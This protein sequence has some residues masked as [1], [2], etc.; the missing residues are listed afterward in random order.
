MENEKYTLYGV[1]IYEKKQDEEDEGNT[2]KKW[3]GIKRRLSQKDIENDFFDSTKEDEED[4]NIVTG[5]KYLNDISNIAFDT[6]GQVFDI[7]FA[8]NEEEGDEEGDGEDEEY[9]YDTVLESFLVETWNTSVK[10]KMGKI[11]K[12]KNNKRVV[13]LIHF[14]NKEDIKDFDSEEK[15]KLENSLAELGLAEDNY[16]RSPKNIAYT[17]SLW[18]F[19]NQIER[20]K[21]MENST[22]HWD[23]SLE[24]K[25]GKVRVKA[26]YKPTFEN[27]IF[28]NGT[29]TEVEYLEEEDTTLVTVEMIDTWSNLKDNNNLSVKSFAIKEENIEKEDEDEE[30]KV[31]LIYEVCYETDP[32]LKVGDSFEL[33]LN[34]KNTRKV[35][36]VDIIVEDNNEEEE[37]VVKTKSDAPKKKVETKSNPV[38]EDEGEEV[39][40]SDLDDDEIPF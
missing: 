23:I 9:S 31:R 34:E 12:T 27:D 26:L 32:K 24:R 40:E 3:V 36:N 21:E 5:F 25:D 6:N 14:I 22:K 11:R 38:V 1:A 28:I 16:I 19:E 15:E 13:Q 17:S 35:K 2:T 29:V 20:F 37:E 30:Q 33:H 18:L 4:E 39:D 8:K 10:L 7:T